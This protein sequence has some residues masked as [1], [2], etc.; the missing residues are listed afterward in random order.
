MMR[1]PRSKDLTAKVRRFAVGVSGVRLFTGA[2]EAWP[3]QL[4]RQHKNEAR[5]DVAC[6]F[7]SKLIV[8]RGLTS[9][10][11]PAVHL[12]TVVD[13]DVLG[14]RNTVAEGVWTAPSVTALAGRLGI[15]MP[16]SAAVN[17]ILHEGADIDSTIAGLLARPIRAEGA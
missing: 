8:V 3:S 11:L 10:D 15:D 7:L 6:R 14:A 13:L 16:I 4:R 2:V 9:V 12:A 5:V 17:A 1:T